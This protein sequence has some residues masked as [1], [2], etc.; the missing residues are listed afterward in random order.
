ME[1]PDNVISIER[2]RA[3]KWGYPDPRI[4]P[5]FLGRRIAAFRNVDGLHVSDNGDVIWR[6]S[7]DN[8]LHVHLPE[9]ARAHRFNMIVSAL[10]KVAY[11][12]V[13]IRAARGRLII[14]REGGTQLAGRDAVIRL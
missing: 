6:L 8:T 2:L 3:L 9:N 10:N 7:H 12:S 5:V 14:E 4:G 11:L 13:G 1:K